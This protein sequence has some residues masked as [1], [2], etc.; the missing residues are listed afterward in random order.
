MNEWLDRVEA[1]SM[2]KSLEKGEIIGSIKLYH[3]EMHLLRSDIVDR[4][5]NRF[6]LDQGEAEKYVAEVLGL[7]LA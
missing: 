6:S 2:K 4:I 5:M 1:N 7:Q 3:D